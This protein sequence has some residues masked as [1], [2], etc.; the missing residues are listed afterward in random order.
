MIPVR[1]GHV[2]VKIC[3]GASVCLDP[4]GR[5]PGTDSS[6]SG[7]AGDVWWW[8]RGSGCGPRYRAALASLAEAALSRGARSARRAAGDG[9]ASRANL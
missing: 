7:L 1:A 6:R 8:A 4:V 3:Q 9:R 2:K 5:S